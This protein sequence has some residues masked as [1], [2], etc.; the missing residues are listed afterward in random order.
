[1]E[2]NDLFPHIVTGAIA[3][4]V[5]WGGVRAN[6]SWIIK[7]VNDLRFTVHSPRNADNLVSKVQAHGFKIEALEREVRHD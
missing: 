7:S 5:A 6:I 2:L 1:M 4:G 3:G